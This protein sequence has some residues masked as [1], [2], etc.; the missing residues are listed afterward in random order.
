MKIL[1]EALL[2]ERAYPGALERVRV[3]LAESLRRPE[4]DHGV[5]AV[6]K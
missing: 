4:L 2:P 1:L 5:G 3:E 6:T